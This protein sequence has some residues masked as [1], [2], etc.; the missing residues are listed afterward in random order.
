MDYFG[1]CPLLVEPG[2]LGDAPGLQFFRWAFHWVSHPPIFVGSLFLQF[3]FYCILNYVRC[4]K[5]G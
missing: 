2:L 1:T 4:A 5:L 3:L